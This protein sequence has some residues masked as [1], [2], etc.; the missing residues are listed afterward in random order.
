M[1][2]DPKS[3]ELLASPKNPD[4]IRLRRMFHGLNYVFNRDHT[5][6]AIY[7]KGEPIEADP[8]KDPALFARQYAALERGEEPPKGKAKAERRAAAGTWNAAAELWLGTPKWKGLADNTKRIY[9]PLIEDIRVSPLGKKLMKRTTPWDVT[10]LHNA[11]IETRGPNAANALKTGVLRP[12]VKVGKLNGWVTVDLLMGVDL[13]EVEHTH[14]RPYEGGE[15]EKWRATHTSGM[16]LYAF[17]LAYALAMATSDLIRFAPKDIDAGNV[18]LGRK[19]TSNK[20]HSNVFADP[21]LREVIEQLTALRPEGTPDDVPFLR[22]QHGKPFQ[23]STFRKQWARWREE[24]GIAE[25]FKVHAARATMVVD[26]KHA[27]VADQD[28][29]HIT[30]HADQKVY[31]DSYAHHADR[32]VQATRAQSAVVAH[33]GG[34]GK[35]PPALRVVA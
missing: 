12:I 18:T 27:G 8:I 26:M 13:Q 11:I 1:L 22:N 19:K 5:K 32:H 21:V 24:A 7:F 28:A 6:V 14:H 16:A 23:T 34:R 25:D 33:R 15:I 17:E 10:A 29:M 20:Q 9:K 31:N 3:V 2:S 30:G 4:R 35:K